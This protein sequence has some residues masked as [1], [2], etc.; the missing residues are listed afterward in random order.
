[1]ACRSLGTGF[2]F[3]DFLLGLPQ[4]TSVQYG[5]NPSGYHFRGNSW[6]LYAQ[7]EWRFRSNLSFNIGLRYEYVS[8]FSETTNQMVNLN[9][10]PGSHRGGS[11]FAWPG[12]P[13]DGNGLPDHAGESQPL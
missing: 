7:D 4:Q 2:D 1:M 3:A 9:I 5:T 8:P 13:A 10:A 12:R 6:D 11:G